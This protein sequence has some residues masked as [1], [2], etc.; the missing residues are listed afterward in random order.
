VVLAAVQGPATPARQSSAE[1][2]PEGREDA[3]AAAE[4]DRDED[5]DRDEEQEERETPPAGDT[6]PG[7]EVLGS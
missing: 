4:R 1:H 7:G 6:A 2:C 3:K 5:V